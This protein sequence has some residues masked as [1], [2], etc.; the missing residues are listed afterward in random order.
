MLWNIFY[1]HDV[2]FV[3]ACLEGVLLQSDLEEVT[4]L[5]Q[6]QA[7]TT[8]GDFLQGLIKCSHEQPD[9]IDLS[10]YTLV[11][12]SGYAHLRTKDLEAT[13]VGC[14]RLQTIDGLI[15]GRTSI[16]SFRS[17]LDVRLLELSFRKAYRIAN[18]SKSVYS[19]SST[20]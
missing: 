10:Q 19:Y 3:A 9:K 1:S 17:S 5:H 20:E 7:Y 13:P 4:L 14:V 16:D 8:E 6:D 15:Y 2:G 11:H 12:N 18:A